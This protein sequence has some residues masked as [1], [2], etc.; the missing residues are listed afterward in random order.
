MENSLHVKKNIESP[1]DALKYIHER[2]VED[3]I[4]HFCFKF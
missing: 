4:A 1:E 3:L 2:A